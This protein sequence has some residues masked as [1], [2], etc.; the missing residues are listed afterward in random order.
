MLPGGN[1][2][3]QHFTENDYVSISTRVKMT[4]VTAQNR[5]GI[6]SFVQ[7]GSF[8]ILMRFDG[9]VTVAQFAHRGRLREL[10]TEPDRALILLERQIIEPQRR[11]SG[12]R[13]S[14]FDSAVR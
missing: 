7:M 4:E 2:T 13:M 5:W 3:S 10:T 8:V 9:K 6:N 12:D 1:P 14:D 11:S